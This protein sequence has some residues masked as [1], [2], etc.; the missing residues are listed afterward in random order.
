MDDTSDS[1][2]AETSGF[3]RNDGQKYAEF[4]DILH[5]KMVFDWYMEVGCRAGRSFAPVRGKTIAVDPFFKAEVNIIGA[6]PRLFVFQDTSDDFFAS[7]FLQQ[8]GIRL[9]FSFLDGMHLCEYLLRDILNTE[10]AS[11]PDG[12]IALHDCIPF[13]YKMLSRDLANLPRGPWTGDVWK[14]IPILR[15]YR[16]EMGVTVLNC[17]P[18]GLVL[19]SNL[20]PGN[21]VLRDHYEEIVAEWAELDLRDYGVARFYEQFEPVDAEAFAAQDYPLFA[22]IRLDPGSVRTPKQVSK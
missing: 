22:K 18:T 19:L 21:T 7:G 13:N 1:E 20:D 12:V 10:A 17:R 15:K 9:S 2:S 11:H 6:K 8:M 16:P 5:S 14:L 3:R 4:L